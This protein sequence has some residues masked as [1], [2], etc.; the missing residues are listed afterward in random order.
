[1]SSSTDIQQY[2]FPEHWSEWAEGE[3][4]YGRWKNWLNRMTP[5]RLAQEKT[6]QKKYAQ[7][8]K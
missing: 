4:M 2:D 6:R 1:M 3:I 8:H 5:E 7:D